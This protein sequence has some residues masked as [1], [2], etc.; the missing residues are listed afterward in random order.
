MFKISL[1]FSRFIG[2]ETT[3]SGVKPELTCSPTWIIDP[4][5]G[6]MNFVHG[7]P[8]VCIS[9]A[10]LVNKVPEIGIIYN[11]ILEQLFTARK[12]QGALL[13]GNKICVSSTTGDVFNFIFFCM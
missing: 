8:I 10:L 3:A 11:P 9:I 13:N 6:T 4:V 7:Y 5:D 1:F 12:G 2:E